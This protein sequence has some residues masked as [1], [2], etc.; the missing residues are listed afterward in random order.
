M[1]KKCFVRKRKQHFRFHVLMMIVLSDDSI[2]AHIRFVSLKIQIYSDEL[3][4][5]EF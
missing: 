2:F 4:E 1:K 3:N 5:V